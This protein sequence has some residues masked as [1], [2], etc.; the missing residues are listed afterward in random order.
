M[1]Q[2]IITED[3]YN[4][5][6][7]HMD[8]AEDVMCRTMGYLTNTMTGIELP[9]R[10]MDFIV[11]LGNQGMQLMG[12]RGLLMDVQQV[13]T[14]PECNGTLFTKS[15]PEGTVRL[16]YEKQL[17][18]M[19]DKNIDKVVEAIKTISNNNVRFSVFSNGQI[20]I[21]NKSNTERIVYYA[22]NGSIVINGVKLTLSG[23][24]RLMRTI[25]ATGDNFKVVEV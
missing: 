10:N 4:A 24:D 17:K 3:I 16:L 2:Y 14:Q 8:K 1:K 23:L 20:N 6:M 19:S 15:T 7:K 9:N 21:F 22:T 11:P 12:L 13:E 5:L 25:D 18:G